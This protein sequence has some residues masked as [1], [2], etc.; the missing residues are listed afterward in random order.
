MGAVQKAL[1]AYDFGHRGVI[2]E[3]PSIL[4]CC[5]EL[6]ANLGLHLI[7]EDEAIADVL[8]GGERGDVEVECLGGSC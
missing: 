8:L 6:I 7:L 2:G 4:V 5:K 3:E 1:F